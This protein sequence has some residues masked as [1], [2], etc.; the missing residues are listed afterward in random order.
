[1]GGLLEPTMGV[2]GGGDEDGQG[3]VGEQQGALEFLRADDIEGAVLGIHRAGAVEELPGADAEAV[4]VEE[5]VGRG[6][7]PER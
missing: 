6:G 3:H 2:M 1:M 7:M 5:E 4:G